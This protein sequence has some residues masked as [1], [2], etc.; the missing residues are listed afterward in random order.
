MQKTDAFVDLLV[1]TIIKVSSKKGFI[2][3]VAVQPESH[4]MEERIQVFQSYKLCLHVIPHLEFQR[5]NTYQWCNHKWC[6]ISSRKLKDPWDQKRYYSP[7]VGAKLQLI[8]PRNNVANLNAVWSCRT[9]KTGA[10]FLVDV[11]ASFFLLV[12][13]SRLNTEWLAH[14]WMEP[15]K[16]DREQ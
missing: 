3:T 4:G 13:L 14:V 9:A 6:V 12:A 15:L 5:E 2:Q 16:F 8:S 1:K 10:S 7:C 11:P